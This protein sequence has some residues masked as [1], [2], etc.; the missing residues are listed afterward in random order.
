MNFD[1]AAGRRGT[2]EGGAVG[3]DGQVARAGWRGDQGHIVF[4]GN[5]SIAA[6]VGLHQAQLFARLYGGVEVDDEGTIGGHRAGADYIAVGITHFNTGPGFA[7][8]A[9]HQAASAD[10]NIAYCSRR[11]NVRGIELQRGGGIASSIHQADIQCLAI[12]LSR[13]KRQA[14]AAI[15]IDQAGTNHVACGVTHL[16]RGAWFAATGKG[17]AFGQGQVGWLFRWQQVLR[18]DR[19]RLRNVACG[20]GQGHLQ[21]AA[22]D[23]GRVKR[24]HEGAVC[25]HGP[26][27]QHIAGDVTHLH[28]GARFATAAELSAGKADHQI[29]RCA[30]WRSVD[31]VDVRRDDRAGKRSVA[32]GVGRRGLQRF[33]I[34]LRRVEGDVEHTS[35][36][37]Q[38]AAQFGAVGGKNTYGAARFGAASDN[39]AVSA[40]SQLAR[41]GRRGDV[42]RGDLCRQGRQ[43]RVIDGD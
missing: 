13:S 42:W 3:V 33:T 36:A 43:P 19:T 27:R 16:H 12:S 22:V 8:T 10:D 31:P 38:R 2:G 25:S 34:D 41:C 15:R 14:E 28:G 39:R 7:A 26:G 9:Q 35:R 18:G 5:R 23:H 24:D 29:G 1:T 21:G 6:R 40:D 37:D 11:R 30:R 20:I 4:K 17:H 32:S